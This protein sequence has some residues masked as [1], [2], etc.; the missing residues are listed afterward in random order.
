[1]ATIYRSIY[2]LHFI[3]ILSAH[4]EVWWPS[5]VRSEATHRVDSGNLDMEDEL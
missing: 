5:R 1:M 3:I 2:T 4:F